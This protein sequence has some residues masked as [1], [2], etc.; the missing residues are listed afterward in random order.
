VHINS[1]AFLRDQDKLATVQKRDAKSDS[2]IGRV[3]GS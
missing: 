3:N 2:Q 1:N